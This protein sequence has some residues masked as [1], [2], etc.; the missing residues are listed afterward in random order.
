MNP[1]RAM[2][3]LEIAV[4]AEGGSAQVLL[5]MTYSALT[6]EGNEM[7]DEGL[8]N[9]IE[10]LLASMV[11]SLRSSLLG[12]RSMEA[13]RPSAQGFR[14][15]RA[16][17]RIQATMQGSADEIFA[18][19]CPVREL[20]WIEDWQFDLIHSVSGYNENHNI[21]VEPTSAVMTLR[22]PFAQTYW[23]TTRWDRQRHHFHALLLTD[24]FMVGKWEFEGEQRP[25]G[26]LSG[27]LQLTYT[28][29]NERGNAIINEPGFESRGR[30]MLQFVLASLRCFVDT[31]KMY[32]VPHKLKL[33]LAMSVI[34]SA[35]G[36]H[37][38]RTH[39]RLLG[40]VRPRPAA[41]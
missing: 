17:V 38:R 35:I 27:S 34:G 30:Q 21:F 12:A 18:L 11:G 9:R 8:R 29:L 10:T 26:S 16:T 19:A 28:A 24:D 2:G 40:H 31:G 37:V 36:R 6:S 3:K 41:R 1:K 13:N 20:E 14:A 15:K 33:Q 7:F 22:S 4:K 23:Y 25:D 39:D 5:E 32:K